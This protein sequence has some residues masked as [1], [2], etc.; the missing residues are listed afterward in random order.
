MLSSIECIT[1]EPL[2]T[3]TRARRSEV[4]PGRDY[5]RGEGMNALQ[6]VIAAL[7]A[8]VSLYEDKY[9]RACEVAEEA[10]R[11]KNAMYQRL[12]AAKNLVAYVESYKETYLDK[13]EQK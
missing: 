10:Q 3:G 7:T 8:D 6:Q 9:A 12:M 2:P 1:T 13:Q 4:T 5:Y 11:H